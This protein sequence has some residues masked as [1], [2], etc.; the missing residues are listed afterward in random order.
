MPFYKIGEESRILPLRTLILVGDGA[1]QMTGWELGN[2]RRLRIDPVVAPF[3]NA[4]WEMLRALQPE[5][6]F[7]DL[8]DWRL[9]AMAASMGGEGRW[10]ASRAELA[11]VPEHG[12][13]S[14][15]RFQSIE[16]MISRGRM[17]ATLQPVRRRR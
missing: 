10:V 6:V 2:C 13:A 17:S 1:F 12:V 4:S 8:D 5:S 16:A 11:A 14:R 9:A 15:S 7:N 3:N